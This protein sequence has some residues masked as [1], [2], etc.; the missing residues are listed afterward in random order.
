MQGLDGWIWTKSVLAPFQIWAPYGSESGSSFFMR[1]SSHHDRASILLTPFPTG[2]PLSLTPELSWQL[3][4]VNAKACQDRVTLVSC[5]CNAGAAMQS[6]ESQ[7]QVSA[8]TVAPLS[9]R[10]HYLY[11]THAHSVHCT[12]RPVI[13]H[14]PP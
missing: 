14:P 12:A 9:L 8:A 3:G 1:L 2:L 4:V 13:A 10:M 11:G 5:N 6:L 7:R